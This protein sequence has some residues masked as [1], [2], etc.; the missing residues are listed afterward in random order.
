MNNSRRHHYIPKFYLKGFCNNDGLLAVYDKKRNILKKGYHSTKSHFFEFNR[1]ILKNAEGQETDFL[2]NLYGHYDNQ[3]SNLFEILRENLEERNILNAQN[4]QNL[5]L[6]IA[7]MFWRVPAAD[8]LVDIFFQGKKLRDIGIIIKSKLTNQS[9]QNDEIEN[10]LIKDPNY[11]EACRFLILPLNT[12]QILLQDSDLNNWN[13]YYSETEAP[14]LCSDVPVVF[15]DLDNFFN[16]QDDLILPLT[17][18]KI[19]IFSNKDKPRILRP[20]FRFNVDVLLFHQAHRYVCGPNRD[21]LN[22]ISEFYYRY[23]NHVDERSLKNEVFC[24][25]KEEL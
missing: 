1:N 15:K 3:L 16:F 14:H 25:L 21:Y 24:F 17:S 12:F 22:A 7:M 20:E 13:Y 9:V 2:E 6:F 8:H 19:L 18:S 10:R 5:K 11:R 23:D 4:I